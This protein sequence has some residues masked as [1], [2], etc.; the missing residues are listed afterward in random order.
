MESPF[1]PFSA[2]REIR[3]QLEFA[4]RVLEHYRDLDDHW[5]DLPTV[6]FGTA[7]DEVRTQ[8]DRYD[9]PFRLAVVGEFK[10]GKSALINALLGRPGLVPEG[11]TPTT[12]AVIEIWGADEE[13]G[14]VVGA[15][16]VLLFTGT[17]AETARYADQRTPEGRKISGRG[18]RI[19]L[20]VDSDLVRNLVVIDTPGLGANDHDDRVTAESLNLADAAILVING[21]RP[22]SDESVRLAERLGRDRRR[23]IAAVTRLDLIRDRNAALDGTREV[24]GEVLDGEPVGVESPRIQAAL[25]DLAD[26]DGD[27]EQEAAARSV[28]AAT[29]Y[30]ELRARVQESLLNGPAA[31][32]RAVRVLTDLRRTLNRLAAAAAGRAA[33]RQQ[34]AESA[35]TGKSVIEQ[36]INDV[37]TPKRPFLDAKI[38]EITHLHLGDYIADLANAVD[39]FIDQVADGGLD[40]GAR[41]MQ[42]RYSESARKRLAGDLEQR[43]KR[44]FPER[45]LEVTEARIHRAVTALLELEWREI[46][47]AATADTSDSRFDPSDLLDQLTDQLR[48]LVGGLAIDALLVG[49]L[50]VPGGILL[51]LVALLGSAGVGVSVLRKGAAR[52]ARVKRQARIQL[53]GTRK[54]LGH[55]IAVHYF[56]INAAVFKQLTE[57]AR[58]EATVQ[59]QA[60]L[61]AL[62]EAERWR[63]AVEQTQRLIADA[64]HFE[65]DG[66][67]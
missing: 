41:A 1:A 63:Q 3:Q 48:R 55:Q 45:Q 67:A 50:F 36:R 23:M 51:E 43:F 35:Q 25:A 46:I 10:A 42:A 24:F 9:E 52:Q 15:D 34:A 44:I 60:R 40:L 39:V 5:D 13:Y 62:G 38:E 56:E 29:G 19:L 65:T 22:G 21:L 12:G 4:V 32:Q 26:A 33:T 61:A 7:I 37:I 59:E 66:I 53:A 18:A 11:K 57:Q 64:R 58:G 8:L 47:E 2:R 16:G 31:G 20:H 54:L 27:P 14:E 6:T 17:L 49:L 30:T 28:L